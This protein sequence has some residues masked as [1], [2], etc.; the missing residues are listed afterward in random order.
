MAKVTRQQEGPE[1]RGQL[2][3]REG[4]HATHVDRSGSGASGEV[5]PEGESQQQVSAQS[6]LSIPLGGHGAQ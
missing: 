2:V 3:L 5:P 1:G 4:S 6:G